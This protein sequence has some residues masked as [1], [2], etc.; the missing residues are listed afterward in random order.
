MAVGRDVGLD[1]CG[2]GSTLGGTG[3]E[4]RPLLTAGLI[5]KDGTTGMPSLDRD[6]SLDGSRLGGFPSG[7]LLGGCGSSRERDLS[8]YSGFI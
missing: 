2:A 1:F 7:G 5:G 6:L 4:E 3:E 8:R